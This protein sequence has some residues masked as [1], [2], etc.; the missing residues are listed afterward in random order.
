MTSEERIEAA[1]DAL[2]ELDSLTVRMDNLV[3]LGQVIR[4]E[5]ELNGARKAILEPTM[6]ILYRL[7]SQEANTINSVHKEIHKTLYGN[8]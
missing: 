5:I 7:L 6:D 4:E 2:E 8:E 1:K 3:T